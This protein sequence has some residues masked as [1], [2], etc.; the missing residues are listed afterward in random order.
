LPHAVDAPA[1]AKVLSQAA[2]RISAVMR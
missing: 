2:S 1:V